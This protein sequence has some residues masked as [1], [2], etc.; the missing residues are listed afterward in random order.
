MQ[1]TS[2]EAH[3]H[4][5]ASSGIDLEAIPKRNAASDGQRAVVLV[6]EPDHRICGLFA[7]PFLR[8]LTRRQAEGD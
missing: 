6:N 7:A 1:A 5:V 3:H 2:L 4:Q 8:L